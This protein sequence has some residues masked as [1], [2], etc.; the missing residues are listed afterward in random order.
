MSHSNLFLKDVSKSRSIISSSL[1][2]WADIPDNAKGRVEVPLRVIKEADIEN[3]EIE[4][5]SIIV[6]IE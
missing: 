6:N 5:K 4:P 2:V 1:Q 3:V